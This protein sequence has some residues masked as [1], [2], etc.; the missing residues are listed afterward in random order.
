MTVMSRRYASGNSVG[1]QCLY[2]E[3]IQ[4]ASMRA[5]LDG[6]MARFAS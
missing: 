6:A 1:R 5:F 2:R 3:G 4:S